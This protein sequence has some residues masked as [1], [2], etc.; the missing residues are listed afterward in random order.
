MRSQERREV[1]RLF[2]SLRTFPA[3]DRIAWRAVELMRAH[4]RSHVGIGLGDY[5]VAATAQIE[6]CELATLN[7]RHFPMFPGLE[8]PFIL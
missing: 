6:G 1:G 4:R 7:I 2:A 5:L 8:P 3:N